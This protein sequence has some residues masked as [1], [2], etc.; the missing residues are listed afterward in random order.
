MFYLIY[1]LIFI[2]SIFYLNLNLKKI[3]ANFC[4]T[5]GKTS[6]NHSFGTSQYFDCIFFGKL[7]RYIKQEYKQER[8]NYLNYHIHENFHKI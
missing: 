4:W 8:Q 3:Y 5:D 2:L 6:Q 1:E 7:G